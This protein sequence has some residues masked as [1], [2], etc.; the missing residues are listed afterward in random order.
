[1]RCP[2]YFNIHDFSW[3]REPA[4]FTVSDDRVEIVTKPHTDLRQRTYYH[5]RNDNAPVFQMET[6]EKFFNFT[7]KTSFEES[8]HRHRCQYQIH[9]VPTQPP[10]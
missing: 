6:E 7:V 9:V 8:H 10:L 4:A 1:M 3:T 5:F 2:V